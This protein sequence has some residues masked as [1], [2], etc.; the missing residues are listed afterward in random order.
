MGMADAKGVPDIT[1]RIGVDEEHAM[2][3]QRQSRRDMDC[4]GSLPHT[5]LM[6]TTA[7]LRHAGLGFPIIVTEIPLAC[8][9]P[10]DERGQTRSRDVVSG[11]PIPASPIIATPDDY[12]DAHH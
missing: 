4:R 7:I 10:R 2:P 3:A 1:L 9:P 8:G 5:P 11:I 6:F 12:T